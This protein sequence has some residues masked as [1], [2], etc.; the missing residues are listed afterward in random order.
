MTSSRRIEKINILMREVISEI[1][2]REVQ[3]PAG[4][5]VTVTRIAATENLRHA[6]VFVSVLGNDDA[7]EKIALAELERLAGAIQYELNRKL[8]MRP[9]PR[10]TFEID[11]EEKR[12][13]RVEKL[14]SEDEG[15]SQN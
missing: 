3:F 15:A 6:K 13:E 5:L 7:V 2:L 4:V 9:V 8:R 11:T 14:L 12:R 10:I 1:L